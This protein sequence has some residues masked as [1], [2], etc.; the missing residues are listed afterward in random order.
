MLLALT[1]DRVEGFIAVPAQCAEPVTAVSVSFDLQQKQELFFQTAFRRKDDG[2]KTK[3][4]QNKTTNEN[5][6]SGPKIHCV[7]C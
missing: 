1:L 7:N 3:Q 5:Y 6:D 2:E 4:K